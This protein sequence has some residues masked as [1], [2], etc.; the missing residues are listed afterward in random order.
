VMFSLKALIVAMA[1][2]FALNGTGACDAKKSAGAGNSNQSKPSGAPVNNQPEPPAEGAAQNADLK[3]LVEGQ[4]SNVSNAFIAVARD[5]ETYAALRGMVPK[6]PEVDKDFFDSNLVMAVFLGERSTGGYGVTFGRAGRGTIR[7]GERKPSKEALVTQAITAPFVVVSV[8][9]ETQESLSIDAGETWRAMMRPYK[10]AEGEFTMAGGFAGR[11]EKFGLAGSLGIMREGN[12]AT[13]LFDLQS[14]AGQ[15]RRLIDAA[16][17]VIQ[18]DGRLMVGH[19]GAGS[20][21]AQPAD[22]LKATGTF[23]ESEKTLSLTFASIPGRVADGY[24]GNGTLKA[25]AT[26][27]AP[28]KRKSSTEEAPQ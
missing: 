9:V 4:H 13:L 19:M 3:V 8:P 24:N 20:L 17:G 11:S 12:L 10:V 23:A 5:A 21:V 2:A 1:L 7:I 15:P 22:A 18:S 6:L 28:Q 27:P 25:E 26:A 14:K 16:S